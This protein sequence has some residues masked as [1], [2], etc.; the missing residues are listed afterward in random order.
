MKFTSTQKIT[1]GSI[2]LLFVT[3]VAYVLL[4]ARIGSLRER[5]VLV[6]AELVVLDKISENRQV[7][8]TLIQDT[9]KKREELLGYFVSTEAPTPFLE[10]IENAAKDTGILLEVEQLS[11]N[12]KKNSSNDDIFKKNVK[13]VL[14]VDGGWQEFYH[15]VSL[16][17]LFPYTNTIT[18]TVFTMNKKEDAGLWSGQIHLSCNAI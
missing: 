10:L 18:N 14:S 16:L 1:T 5:L 8:T 7:I 12:D 11:T 13:V 15:L 17:E 6:K 2:L 3:I 9:S 4:F